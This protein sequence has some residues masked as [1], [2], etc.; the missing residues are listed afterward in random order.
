MNV[1]AIGLLIALAVGAVSWALTCAAWRFDEVAAGVRPLEPRSFERLTLITLGTGGAHEDHNRRGPVTAVAVGARVLLVD[2]GRGV[3]ESLR[4]AQI[5]VSQPDTVLLTNLLPE[6]TLGLD[7]LLAMAWI[8]GRRQPLALR[9]PAGTRTLA[10]AVEAAVRPGIEARARGLGLEVEAPRFAVEEIGDAWRADFGELRVR[11]GELPGG[12]VAALAY[13]FEWRERSAVVAGTGWAPDALS[14]LAR[15]VHV[16]V[17]EA[18]FVPSPELAQEMQ[19]DADA[20]QLRREAALHTGL[21]DVG[22][23]ARRAGAH[24]LVL[25][26]LRPPPVFDLQ[27]SSRVNDRYAGRI[28]VASD[29]EEITP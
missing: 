9:G 20:E 6:N 28:V 15:G 5:P 23:L 16:L 26:R 8:D 12:P 24:S 13:R 11:A 22:D 17:H 10:A 14:D 21:D 2:A 25:V 29:G 3:A 7:D 19:L 27:V 18:V 4:A 1:R